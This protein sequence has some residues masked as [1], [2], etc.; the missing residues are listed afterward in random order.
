VDGLRRFCRAGRRKRFHLRPL[1]SFS[2]PD[3][4]LPRQ[5]YVKTIVSGGSAERDGVLPPSHPS[6]FDFPASAGASIATCHRNCHDRH[7]AA[8]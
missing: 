5:V 3:F 7:I 6:P 1:M 2:S 8:G 4:P